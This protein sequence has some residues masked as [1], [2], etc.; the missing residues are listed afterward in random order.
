MRGA[1]LDEPD[2]IV[3]PGTTDLHAGPINF[4]P[5]ADVT[6]P[7]RTDWHLVADHEIEALANPPAGSTGAVGF[8]ALGAALGALPSGCTAIDQANSAKV[9]TAESFRALLVLAICGSL[10]VACLAFF[11][12]IRSTTKSVLKTIRS[13]PKRRGKDFEVNERG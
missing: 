2:Q 9:M 4:S 10:A 5:I 6:V 7:D 13:R 8:A 3:P 12:Y 1:R 11:F